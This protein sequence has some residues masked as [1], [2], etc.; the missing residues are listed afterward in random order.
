MLRWDVMAI[1]L[2][3]GLVLCLED[4]FAVLE[5]ITVAGAGLKPGATMD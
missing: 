3:D 2:I 1:F 4:A 5:P